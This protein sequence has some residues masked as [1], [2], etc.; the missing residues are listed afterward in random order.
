MATPEEKARRQGAIAEA[1][2]KRRAHELRIRVA[3]DAVLQTE[4]GRVLWAHLFNICGYNRSSLAVDPR[5]GDAMTQATQH[6]EAMR[7][8]YLKMRSLVSPEVLVKAERLAEFGVDGVN[9]K[10]QEKP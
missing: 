5:S 10:S 2:E 1:A 3:V 9:E 8:V 4:P 7:M 6:N